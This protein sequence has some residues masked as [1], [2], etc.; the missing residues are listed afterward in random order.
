MM[1]EL[2]NERCFNWRKHKAS[3]ISRFIY[4]SHKSQ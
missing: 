3:N 1:T 2:V 4:F